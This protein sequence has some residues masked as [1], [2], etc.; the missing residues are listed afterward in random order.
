MEFHNKK[1]TGEKPFN[2]DDCGYACV[3]KS[4]LTSHIKQHME[5]SLYYCKDCSFE[6]KFL[7][8]YKSHLI[9]KKHTVGL[10]LDKEGNPVENFYIDLYGRKRGPRV[11]KS[12]VTE[13]KTKKKKTTSSGTSSPDSLS[14]EEVPVDVSPAEEAAVSAAL[15]QQCAPPTNGPGLATTPPMLLCPE[16]ALQ[17]RA[18]MEAAQLAYMRHYFQTLMV[19]DFRARH[20]MAAAVVAAAAATVTTATTEANTSSDEETRN[21]TVPLNLATRT[22]EESQ[23]VPINLSK[24]SHDEENH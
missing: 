10:V 16:I 18:V 12:K 8:T 17:Q 24:N 5:Y 20:T 23:D 19:T 4:M 14:S 13:T 22:E 3:N 15:E 7:N 6:A 21:T 2:C 11:K 9:K 1:H